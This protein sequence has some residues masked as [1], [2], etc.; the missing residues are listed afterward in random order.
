MLPVWLAGNELLPAIDVVGRTREGRVGHDVYGE[1]GPAV[2]IAALVLRRDYM[3][4]T[5]R[6]L[7]SFRII[8]A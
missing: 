2:A 3:V 7:A 4:S 8:R 6:N 5:M 1:R